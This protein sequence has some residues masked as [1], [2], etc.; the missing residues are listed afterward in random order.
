MLPFW[1]S[2]SLIESLPFRVT[3]LGC[4]CMTDSLISKQGIHFVG[5]MI[6]MNMAMNLWT[7]K[8]YSSPPLYF[9]DAQFMPTAMT[10]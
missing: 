9:K 1:G 5:V 7:K 4:T 8:G 3:F 10:P 6:L 2:D